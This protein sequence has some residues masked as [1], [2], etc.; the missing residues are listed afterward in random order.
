MY[1]WARRPPVHLRYLSI[2]N[3]RGLRGL[4]LRLRRDTTV[5]IGENQWGSTSL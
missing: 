5:L 4:Q 1:G 2:R 3:F